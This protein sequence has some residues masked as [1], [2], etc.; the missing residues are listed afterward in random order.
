MSEDDWEKFPIAPN[1]AA[2]LL[3][4]ET[5]LTRQ[6]P[7]CDDQPAISDCAAPQSGIRQRASAVNLSLLLDVPGSAT[8][9]SDASSNFM[10]HP[11][12]RRISVSLLS[13]PR[14]KPW[15]EYRL[16]CHA[17]T[18]HVRAEILHLRVQDDTRG[19][20]GM[21]QFLLGRAI[22]DD[23]VEWT[24]HQIQCVQEEVLRLRSGRSLMAPASR[25]TAGCGAAF[26]YDP[27]AFPAPE[28]RE[29]SS[30]THQTRC[31]RARAARSAN[32]PRQMRRPRTSTRYWGVLP[33]TGQ[34][35]R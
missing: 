28:N 31:R 21:R 25:R 15:I 27:S 11:E 16:G 33:P 24:V 9:R 1:S 3:P 29:P 18:W 19:G 4:R 14:S 34:L 8:A 6:S 13:L 17:F 23:T 26:D 32:R 30:L 22:Q 2:W 7:T 20:A 5:C 12:E 35:M 10:C